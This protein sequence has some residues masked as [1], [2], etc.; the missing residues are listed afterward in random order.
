M[1][2]PLYCWRCKKIVPM[3]EEH[4]W[5]QL[6]PSLTEAIEQIKRYREEHKVSINEARQH[7]YGQAAMQR[8]F[9]LTG[10]KVEHPDVLLHHRLILFGPPCRTCGKPLRT[11]KA[12]ICAECGAERAE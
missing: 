3:L 1:A 2:K 6:A 5:N 11:P 8:Y 7:G 4:E 12:K 9:E 10:S